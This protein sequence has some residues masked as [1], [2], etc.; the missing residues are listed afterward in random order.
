MFN[1]IK[2]LFA[3]I[4][5]L[6][7]TVGC[8]SIGK[9]SQITIK[10]ETLE[11]K[12]M[13][14]N[15]KFGDKKR[16]ALIRNTPLSKNDHFPMFY[17]FMVHNMVRSMYIRPKNKVVTVVDKVHPSGTGNTD[18]LGFVG[19]SYPDES[20]ILQELNRRFSAFQGYTLG[21]NRRSHDLKDAYMSSERIYFEEK[22]YLKEAFKK[23]KTGRDFRKAVRREIRYSYICNLIGPYCTFEFFRWKRRRL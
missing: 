11:Q 18:S 5:V 1:Q 12:L 14:Q 3:F 8:Q 20:I 15:D 22:T 9:K 17:T 7:L 6:L 13:T 10:S 2:L 19:I 21:L 4:F 23:H 16:E